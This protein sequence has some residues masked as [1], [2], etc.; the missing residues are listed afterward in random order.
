MFPV[1]A[2]FCLLCITSSHTFTNHF[3]MPECAKAHL[4]Q[5]RI[6]K[7]S[8]GEDPRTPPAFRGGVK[9]SGDNGGRG[10]G[11]G[12]GMVGGWEGKG[13]GQGREENGRVRREASPKQKYQDTTGGE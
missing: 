10:K 2:V 12:K 11:K 9:G 4:Q 6:S 3:S 5:S 8:P 7:K 1:S 13:N